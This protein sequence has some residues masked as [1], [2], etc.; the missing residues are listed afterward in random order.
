M[1]WPRIT[2]STGKQCI[3]SDFGILPF[4]KCSNEVKVNVQEKE[5]KS[6]L[7]MWPTTLSQSGYAPVDWRIANGTML[8]KHH[9][10]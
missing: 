9:G 3:F 6:G 10:R 7:I 5:S 8:A 2:T 1:I 4:Q